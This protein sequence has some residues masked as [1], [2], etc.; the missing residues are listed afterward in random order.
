MKH[1]YIINVRIKWHSSVNNWRYTCSDA[2]K[3]GMTKW[4]SKSQPQLK[5]ED[6]K[7]SQNPTE[8]SN[9][10]KIVCNPSEAEPGTSKGKR[11]ERKL[12]SL[13][14]LEV[15]LKDA[16]ISR[17]D[18]SPQKLLSTLQGGILLNQKRQACFR[19]TSL[20][21]I[22]FRFFFFFLSSLIVLLLI[23]RVTIIWQKYWVDKMGKN[24]FMIYPRDF[25]ITWSHD[26]R[27]WGWFLPEEARWVPIGLSLRLKMT[28]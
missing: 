7:N 9:K 10:D 26:N 27:H 19:S 6:S 22:C 4:W 20:V 2:S 11:A 14:K 1:L 13:Q 24:C 21:L 28:L 12:D 3:M 18:F 8:G 5:K 23:V 15:I 17:E 16:N 25:H